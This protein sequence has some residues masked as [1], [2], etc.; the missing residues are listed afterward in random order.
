V[1]PDL[2][3]SKLS[4][5]EKDALIL[6]LLAR[7][8][9]AHKLIAE[10][11]ARIDDLTRPG[12][13]PNNSSVPPLKGTSRTGLTRPSVR[14]RARAVSAARVAG[15]H[16]PPSPTKWCWPSRRAATIASMPSLMPIRGSTRATTR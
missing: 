6:T 8:D 2:D 5:A 3:L 11:Q 7:L 12:K 10:L 1:S 15:G 4:H 9:E 14:D 16:S 13:T